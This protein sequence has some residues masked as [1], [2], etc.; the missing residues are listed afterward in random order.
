MRDLLE[1]LMPWEG[2][3]DAVNLCMAVFEWANDYDHVADRDLGAKP[4]EQSLHDAMWAI[5]V[6]IPANPFYRAHPELAVTL[7]NGI[8]NWRA[9]N[10]LVKSKDVPDMILAHVL[11]WTLIEFFLHCARLVGGRAWADEQAPGFW[12]AMTRD[13]S[14][15]EFVAEHTEAT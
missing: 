12:R 9:S 11:R 14:F 6:T 7:A 5:A 13:H 1:R 4:A 8:S 3:A 2:S 10:E 15:G